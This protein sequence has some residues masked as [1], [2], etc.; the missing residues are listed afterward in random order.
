MNRVLLKLSNELQVKIASVD[1]G[2]LRNA[3]PRESVA[4]I[5]VSNENVDQ[6]KKSIAR[7]SEIIRGEYYATDPNLDLTFEKA[8]NVEKVLEDDFQFK[9]LRSIYACPNGIY[10]MSP[11]IAGL[12]QSSN[13][14][15]RVLVQSGNYSIQCLSRSALDSEKSDLVQSITSAF[16]LSGATVEL[17]SS[18]PGWEPRPDAPIVELM[19]GLYKELFNETANVDA[20]HAGLECGILGTNYPGMQMISFGPNITGAHSPDEKV[21]VSSVQKFWYFLIET[22]K[23]IPSKN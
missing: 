15:A 8:G 12:V 13:N 14:I 3:I 5:V 4:T 7:Q 6:L 19:A 16:E 2:S 22:L 17:G 9:L 20:I 10:R 21:Q 18:Y 23:R 11:G 1:G